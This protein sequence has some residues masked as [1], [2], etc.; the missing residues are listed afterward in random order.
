ML[1]RTISDESG[2][3]LALTL[4][5]LGIGVLLLPVFLAHASTNLFATRAVEEGLQEQYA[6]DSGIEY[7]LWQLQTGVFSGTA[8][9]GVNNKAVD[10]TWTEYISPIY[11]ITSTATTPGESSTTIVSYVISNTIIPSVFD[12]AAVALGSDE[13]ECDL[14]FGGSFETGSVEILGGDVYANGNICT[15]GSG[16]YIDGDASATGVI[17]D[18]HGRIAGEKVQGAPEI[19]PPD[20]DLAALLAEAEAGGVHVGDWSTNHSKPLGPLHITGN[21][22]IGGNATVTLQGTVYVDGNISMG[23][24]SDMI[25]GYIIVAGGDITLRGNGKIDPANFPFVI[26]TGGNITITGNNY[27]SAVVYAPN[28][29]ITLIGNAMLYGAAVGAS[30]TGTGSGKIDYPPGLTAARGLPGGV[31]GLEIRTYNFYP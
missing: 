9:Y 7:A 22:S 14:N 17:T 10:V 18:T 30:V 31:T 13:K 5:I 20:I 28:G 27:T 26:S 4:I 3:A 8:D 19:S 21:L 6:A 25:G 12:H 15:W 16:V 23:G 1:K 11:V 2:R 29:D 24:N